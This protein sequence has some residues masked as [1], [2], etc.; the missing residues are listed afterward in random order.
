MSGRHI[1]VS[2]RH[3][4]ICSN[5]LS[6]KRVRMFA[7]H[8]MFFVFFGGFHHRFSMETILPPLLE[9]HKTCKASDK[10]VEM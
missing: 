6:S 4:G 10:H 5:K 1:K 9:M 8:L 3:F 7:G 2:E